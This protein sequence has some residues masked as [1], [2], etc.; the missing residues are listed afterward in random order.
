MEARAAI[1][2]GGAENGD[3]IIKYDKYQW[4]YSSLDKVAVNDWLIP[5]T[6]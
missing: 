3:G 4:F 1:D 6:P 2:G 5:A